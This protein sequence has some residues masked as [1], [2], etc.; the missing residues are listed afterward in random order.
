MRKY[1]SFPPVSYVSHGCS[2]NINKIDQNACK[3]LKYLQRAKY[4]L[5]RMIKFELVIFN[6]SDIVFEADYVLHIKY[7]HFLL[8][9]H[10]VSFLRL[11]MSDL[12]QNISAIK[13]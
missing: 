1:I 3:W 5:P 13:H 9:L 7:F 2:F 8:G 11:K 6:A 10:D 4:E 12:L